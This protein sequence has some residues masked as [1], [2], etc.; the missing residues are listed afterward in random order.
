MIPIPLEVRAVILVTIVA[1][2]FFAGWKV[3]SALVDSYELKDLKEAI[4]ERD[5]LQEK[6]NQL[7]GRVN[8]LIIENNKVQERI[9]ERTYREIEKPVYKDCILPS[10]GVDLRN[11]QIRDLNR[12][13]RGDT[14]R[15]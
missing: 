5:E 2:S 11:E 12:S 3:K 15:E 1:G 13:I 7:S 8:E 10:S 6:V 4:K 14:T 9:I